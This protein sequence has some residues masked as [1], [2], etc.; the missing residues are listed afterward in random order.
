MNEDRQ[1][2]QSGEDTR[3]SHTGGRESRWGFLSDESQRASLTEHVVCWESQQ[4]SEE[5][6]T[7]HCARGWNTQ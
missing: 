4:K 6:M 5:E 3:G 2:G 1:R 7:L